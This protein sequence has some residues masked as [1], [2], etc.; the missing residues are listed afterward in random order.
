[1]SS[2]RFARSAWLFRFEQRLKV[3]NDAEKKELQSLLDERENIRRVSCCW[4][5]KSR[6]NLQRKATSKL[7]DEVGELRSKA[8][9][10]QV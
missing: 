4:G 3:L 1:M 9:V 5:S 2:E 10:G 6:G 7:M 8:A